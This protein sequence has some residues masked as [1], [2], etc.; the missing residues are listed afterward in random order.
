MGKPILN[1]LA[2][3][4]TLSTSLTHV[5]ASLLSFFFPKIA[6]SPYTTLLD[7]LVKPIPYLSVVNML[8]ALVVLAL[9]WPLLWVLRGGGRTLHASFEARLL[10]VLP[11]A[12]VAAALDYW[13]VDVA[14]GYVLGMGVYAWAW[15]RG[16]VGFLRSSFVG[17]RGCADVRVFT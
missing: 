11:L 5:L 15:C 7:A 2:R 6:W 1:H 17:E 12:G 9:E 14:V 3:L 8:L 4:L 16:E 10:G 13:T